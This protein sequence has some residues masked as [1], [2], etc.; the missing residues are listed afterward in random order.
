MSAE[1]DQREP[2]GA[3]GAEFSHRTSPLV[4]RLV[5]NFLRPYTGR[6]V[7]ALLC[8]ALVAAATA[9]NAWLMQPM[10]DR[11]FVGHD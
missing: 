6:M 1:V 10:L 3:P 5:G 11:V 2:P 9:G 4:R 7:V 8:M